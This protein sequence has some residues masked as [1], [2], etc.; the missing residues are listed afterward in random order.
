MLHSTKSY[1]AL[2]LSKHTVFLSNNQVALAYLLC[3]VCTMFRAFSKCARTGPC[4]APKAS[5]TQGK[6]S[7]NSNKQH[8]KR[9]TAKQQAIAQ[10]KATGPIT[11]S[12]SDLVFFLTGPAVLMAVRAPLEKMRQLHGD[13]AVMSGLCMC[14]AVVLRCTSAAAVCHTCAKR[15][16]MYTHTL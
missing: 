12:Y 6:V 15:P 8:N 7:A 10:A 11:V 13:E 14:A 2:L 4:A 16:V 9:L 1:S 3:L 5:K